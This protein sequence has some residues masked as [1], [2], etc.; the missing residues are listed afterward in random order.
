MRRPPYRCRLWCGVASALVLLALCVQIILRD[1]VDPVLLHINPASAFLAW[2]SLHVFVATVLAIVAFLAHRRVRQF[3][4][5]R[6]KPI[7][8][9]DGE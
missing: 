7:E 9:I 4:P 8:R 1:F 5:F 3:S 2:V 6:A